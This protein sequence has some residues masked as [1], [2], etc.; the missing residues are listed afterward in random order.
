[1][2]SSLKIAIFRT[3]FA[4]RT[5]KMV[6]EEEFTLYIQVTSSSNTRFSQMSLNLWL[7]KIVTN[8]QQG[9][10]RYQMKKKELLHFQQ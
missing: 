1:M 4:A 2:K 7:K 5:K 3:E 8:F 9:E 6:S 10:K